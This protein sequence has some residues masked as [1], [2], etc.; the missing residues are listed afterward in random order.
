MNKRFF[1][2]ALA[3]GAV[4][5]ISLP[6]AAQNWK[7]TRPINLIVPWAAGGSTDQVTRVTAAELEK[8]LGQTIVIV[9]QPGASGAIG[10]KSA[11][12]APKDGYTWT[13]GAAQDLG[14]YQ[15]L[16]SVNTSIKDWHLF[17]NVANVQVIGVN[18]SRPWHTAKELLDDMHKRPGQISVATAG[19]TS[20]AHAAMDEIV[21]ATGVKYKEV[22]YDGGNPAVVA[23][24]AG[25]A[26]L[27]TQLAVE[28]A[29]MIRGKRL[30]PLA[31]VSNKPLEL[32]GYGTI[33]P[34]SA[35]VPG[36]HA[37]ANYFGIFIPKGVP[38]EVVKTVERL[39]AQNIAKSEALKKYATS[40][41][42]LFDPLYGEEAQ[43]AVWPAVQANAWNL[44]ASGKT[45]VSPDTVGIPKP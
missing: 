30:R 4:L 15:S 1:L 6:A 40:R 42:A 14:A 33:P 25:E 11:L 27:T 35:T 29:D 2:H 10:T 39:W 8:A 22:S 31:V 45:K 19:V 7:P 28:Q 38:D 23:T 26:D 9:N 3:A 32:E 18:P 21:K 41:G 44:H 12:D 16:G 13:A 17:L 37:P 20:A 5:A 34:L 43:K 24:V 36:F